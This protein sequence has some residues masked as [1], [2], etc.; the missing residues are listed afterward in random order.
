M[1]FSFVAL[2]AGFAAI[3]VRDSNRDNADTVSIANGVIARVLALPI[4]SNA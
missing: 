1:K 2:L 4:L 3:A